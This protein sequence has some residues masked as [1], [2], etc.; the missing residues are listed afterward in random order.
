MRCVCP[1]LGMDSNANVLRGFACD[2]DELE[3][4]VFPRHD[5]NP[6]VYIFPIFSVAQFF[7][8][9]QTSASLRYLLR[10]KFYYNFVYDFVVFFPITH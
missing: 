8:T 10:F 6:G 3:I 7:L 1:T 9:A 4:I 2:S 5:F